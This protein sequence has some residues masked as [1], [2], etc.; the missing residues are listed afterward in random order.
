MTQ[1]FPMI[2]FF[3]F[4]GGGGVGGGGCGDDKIKILVLCNGKSMSNKK[5]VH[6]NKKQRVSFP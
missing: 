4:G 6:K 5:Q 1:L 3:F 2:F